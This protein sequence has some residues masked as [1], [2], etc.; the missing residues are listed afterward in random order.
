MLCFRIQ[1]IIK[2]IVQ[3]YNHYSLGLYA[4]FILGS[5]QLK[6]INILDFSS[7]SAGTVAYATPAT[8]LIRPWLQMHVWFVIHL[9]TLMLKGL[10]LAETSA[11]TIETRLMPKRLGRNV[12]HRPN[13]PWPK[14]KI[15]ALN[16]GWLR[17]NFLIFI[18]SQ[19]FNTFLY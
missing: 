19:S 8:S 11:F 4:L 18:L 1:I 6:K 10:Y 2:D 14:H 16:I 3:T 7:H 5:H 13:H 9:Y 17:C 12:T 15:F